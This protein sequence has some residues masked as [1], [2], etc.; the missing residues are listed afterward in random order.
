M[1]AACSGWC[2][3]IPVDGKNEAFPGTALWN[4]LVLRNPGMAYNA[5]F[6]KTYYYNNYAAEIAPFM[7]V[8]EVSNELLSGMALQA[9]E[10]FQDAKEQRKFIKYF[11]PQWGRRVYQVAKIKPVNAAAKV[12]LPAGLIRL[13]AGQYPAKMIK[14]SQLCLLLA[15]GLLGISVCRDRLRPMPV[16]G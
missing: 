4:E 11:G 12:A 14:R 15:P 1:A 8:S 2:S 9:R 10:R 6:T 16:S 5:D 3:P 7:N 13:P